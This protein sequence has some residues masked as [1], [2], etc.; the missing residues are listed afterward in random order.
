VRDQLEGH[1]THVVESFYHCHPDVQLEH[2]VGARRLTLRRSQTC[3][4]VSYDFPDLQ[5]VTLS[6]MGMGGDDP[7]S[8]RFSPCYGKVVPT[9][10]IRFRQ[11]ATLPAKWTV[12][13]LLE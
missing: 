9:W 6:R 10:S 1:G 13:F 3:V 2:D 12:E 7:S 8:G 5:A 11:A 4:R